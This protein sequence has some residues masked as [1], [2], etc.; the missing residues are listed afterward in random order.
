MPFLNEVLVANGTTSLG[1]VVYA[2]ALL[3]MITNDHVIGVAV[4]AAG[5]GYVV[6]ESFDISGGTAIGAFN[7]RGVVTSVS[8]GAVTGVKVISAGAYSTLPGVTGAAT[9]NASASGNNALTVNLTTQTA[10][11]TLDAST[12]VDDVTDFNWLASSVKASNAPTIGMQTQTSGGNDAVRTITASNYN[13]AAAWTGQPDASPDS[14]MYTAIASQNPEI[15]VSTTERRVNYVCRDGNNVQYGGFGLFIP[16]TNADASYPFPGITH[17]Q[18]TSLRAFNLAYQQDGNGSNNAGVCNPGS[19]TTV[20]PAVRYR[21]NLS[22]QWKTI[23]N[24]AVS[25]NIDASVWPHNQTTTLYSMTFAP[26]LSG[27]STDPFNSGSGA[28]D[29]VLQDSEAN[30][31]GWFNAPNGGAQGVQGVSPLGTGLQ[32]TFMVD[33]HIISSSTGDTQVIGLIDG[34]SNCHGVGLTAFEELETYQENT[35]YIVFPDTNG[36]DLGQWVGMEII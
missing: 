31:N 5:A 14:Q 22:V 6:G 10:R 16:L 21:D 24:N 27:R 25:S 26:Q 3:D 17:A 11:W 35:R 29:C 2:K 23:A 13:G 33:T 20:F 12:Y 1:R 32:M 9:T 36:T 34:Y 7:A 28:L 30:A 4:N 19:Y 18:S 8:G 15:Y